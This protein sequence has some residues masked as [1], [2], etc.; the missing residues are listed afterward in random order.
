MFSVHTVTFSGIKDTINA[1][2]PYQD[3]QVVGYVRVSYCSPIVLAYCYLGYPY[4]CISILLYINMPITLMLN[5]Y[6]E[7]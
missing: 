6:K 2:M 1:L 7:I 3:L 4:T 5:A